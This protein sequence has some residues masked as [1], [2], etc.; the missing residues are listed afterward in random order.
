M[1]RRGQATHVGVESTGNRRNSL[2]RWK[3]VA[4]LGGTSR[5][6]RK[7]HVRICGRIGAKF[8][9]PTRQVLFTACPENFGQALTQGSSLTL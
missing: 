4:F 1:E 6:N 3:A 9:G 5:M 7:V 2:S 8:P